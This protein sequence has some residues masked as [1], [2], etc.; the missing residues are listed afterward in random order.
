MGPIADHMRPFAWTLPLLGLA[1]CS[2]SQPSGSSFGPG[3]TTDAASARYEPD[4]GADADTCVAEGGL[5]GIRCQQS[6][7]AYCASG[8][9]E[10]PYAGCGSTWPGV[11]AAPP[12]QQANGLQILEA[13]CGSATE[14]M[15]I[16]GIDFGTSYFYDGTTDALTAVVGFSDPG[17]PTCAAGPPCFA[18]P[19]CGHQHM[20][21]CLDAGVTDAAESE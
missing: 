2:T 16:D 15:S 12:C 7:A 4:A 13:A 18:V 1:A 21:S 11:Q 10:F 5:A 9:V 20:V 6:L 3:V 17:I 14:V 8:Q 19:T